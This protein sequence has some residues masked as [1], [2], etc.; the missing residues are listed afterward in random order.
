MTAEALEAVLVRG[1]LSQ[2]TAPQRLDYLRAVCESVHLNPLTQPFS[3]IEFDGKLI[4]YAKKDCAEQLRNIHRITTKIVSRQTEPDGSTYSVIAQASMP[5]GRS[6]D[7]IGV[8]AL[9]KELGDF[10]KAQNGKTYFEPNGQ[11]RK[12]SPVDRA[13]AQMRAE[14]KAKRRATLSLCGL[15]GIPDESELDTMPNATKQNGDPPSVDER[16]LRAGR[17]A[18]TIIRELNSL[19]DEY[20]SVAGSDRP[21]YDVIDAEGWKSL[22]EVR[23]RKIR[24]SHELISALGAKL[25]KI[26]AAINEQPPTEPAA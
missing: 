17:R 11:Y 3:Y 18:D 16:V 22:D 20:I 13:N 15:G 8:V 1:D 25:E 21:Y 2:L 23:T 5:N 9:Q 19:R 14:T 7:A 12:L 6:E 10:K 24:E 26:H 4:L